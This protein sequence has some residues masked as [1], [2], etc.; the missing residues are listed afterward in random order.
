MALLG[1]YFAARVHCSNV[2][3]PQDSITGDM[4]KTEKQ[5]EAKAAKAPA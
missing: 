3:V 1:F 2:F 5:K 4:E